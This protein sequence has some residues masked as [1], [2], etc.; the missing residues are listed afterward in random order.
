[1][2]ELQEHPFIANYM[3]NS[4]LT[5]MNIDA[6]KEGLKKK[7]DVKPDHFIMP[8][9]KGTTP[10]G[11]EDT[12]SI[13]YSTKNPDQLNLLVEQL[14]RSSQFNNDADLSDSTYFSKQEIKPMETIIQ[15]NTSND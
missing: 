13:V 7:P 2:E 12:W 4:P 9:P 6:F 3:K 1:M 10:S 8:D 11:G 14:V 5:Q 15:Q